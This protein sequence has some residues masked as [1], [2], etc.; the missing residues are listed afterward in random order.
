MIVYNKH[1]PEKNSD[2]V[3]M[4]Q[5]IVFSSNFQN[6]KLDNKCTAMAVFQWS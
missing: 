6:H 3:Y 5:C 4:Q 2:L 1:P